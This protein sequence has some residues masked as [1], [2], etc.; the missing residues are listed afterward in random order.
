MTF[1]VATLGS[2]F[3][4]LSFLLQ[5]LRSFHGPIRLS[6]LLAQK[7]LYCSFVWFTVLQSGRTTFHTP[8][9]T[10]LLPDS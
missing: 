10:T 4:D 6:N 2:N 5:R 1:A 7:Y 8:V 9:L 3:L